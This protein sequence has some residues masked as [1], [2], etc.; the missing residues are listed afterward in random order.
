M[1]Y[2]NQSRLESAFYVAD[3]L[4]VN[5]TFLARHWSH[6]R[7]KYQLLS[8]EVSNQLANSPSDEQLPVDCLIPWP[9]DFR[10]FPVHQFHRT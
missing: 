10:G 9:K 5:L 4:V 2:R 3:I 7:R 1:L 6:W 8:G